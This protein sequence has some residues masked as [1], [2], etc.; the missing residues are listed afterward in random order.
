MNEQIER[1]RVMAEEFRAE[2]KDR[3]EATERVLDE[4]R[5]Q[6]IS[7]NLLIAASCLQDAEKAG[8]FAAHLEH[9][10]AMAEA[11]K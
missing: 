4:Y 2:E 9:A 1:F 11:G 10:I 6:P 8:R 3:L 7:S 5:K